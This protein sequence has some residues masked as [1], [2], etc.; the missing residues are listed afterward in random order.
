MIL[1]CDVRNC[2]GKIHAKKLCRKHYLQMYQYGRILSR[3]KFDPNEIVFFDEYVE[4]VL[5]DRCH[6]EVNRAIEIN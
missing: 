4:I 3:T 5:Y 1:K 2:N 6:R